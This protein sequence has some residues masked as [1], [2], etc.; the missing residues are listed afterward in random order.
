MT[1]NFLFANISQM[2]VK[3]E[4]TF[5]LGRLEISIGER[6]IPTDTTELI[7]AKKPTGMNMTVTRVLKTSSEGATVTYSANGNLDY[8]EVITYPYVGKIL[9]E[10]V[11]R[12]ERKIGPVMI[13]KI[14]KWEGENGK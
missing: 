9:D 6:I 4:T 7:D 5:F 14:Y 8:N 11:I 10:A 13:R 3:C 1:K 2:V 12:S